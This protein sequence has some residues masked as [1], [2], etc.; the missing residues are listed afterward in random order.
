MGH[1]C[2]Q[3]LT[4]RHHAELRVSAATRQV[5]LRE[6]Q[7][8]QAIQALGPQPAERVEELAERKPF[9]RGEHRLAIEC[10]KGD[11][12]AM[13]EHVL[14]ARHPV[15]ALAVNQVPDDVERAP[16]AGALGCS[17]PGVGKTEQQRAENRGRPPQNRQ[18]VVKLKLH[19]F[20][21]VDPT[22]GW[23]PLFQRPGE[24]GQWPE[25]AGT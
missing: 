20:N 13:S 18:G 19:G 25:Q 12:V 24:E 15:G 17:D 3:V 21:I 1:P 8:G 16:G 5:G 4:Q 7:R 2:R 11:G 23:P 10:R 22:D 9:G 14:D 6:A